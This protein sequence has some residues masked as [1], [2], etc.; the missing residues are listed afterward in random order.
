MNAKKMASRF[1][2]MGFTANVFKKQK[3]YGISVTRKKK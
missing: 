3:G 1:R 2:R